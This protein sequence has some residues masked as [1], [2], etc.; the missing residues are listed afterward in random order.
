M[1]T[2][3]LDNAAV[4][5]GTIVEEGVRLG[6]RY[7][8]DCG[9]ARVGSQGILRAG[10]IVYGD[11]EIGDFFQSG[12]GAVIRAKVRIGD[13]CTILNHTVLEGIVRLGR[14]PLVPETLTATELPA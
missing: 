14:R 13:H 11:V 7:H 8:P 4:G 10:T 2:A 3:T 5:E 12:H 9:P 1:S 6:W